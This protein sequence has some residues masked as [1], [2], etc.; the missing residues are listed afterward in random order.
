MKTLK[1]SLFGT[2]IGTGAWLLGMTQKMWPRHPWWA[3]FFVTI[4]ATVL[5]TYVL[6]EPE[7]K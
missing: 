2:I 3:V 7:K 4:A 1:A 6:P 5:L